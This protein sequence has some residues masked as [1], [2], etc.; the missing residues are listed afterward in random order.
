[1]N[2]RLGSGYWYGMVGA[3]VIPTPSHWIDLPTIIKNYMP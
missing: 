1:M 2:Y 3:V